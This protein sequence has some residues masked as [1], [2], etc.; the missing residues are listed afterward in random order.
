MGPAGLK[1]YVTKE[2]VFKYP[3]SLTQLPK[4]SKVWL[5][6]GKNAYQLLRG[7]RVVMTSYRLLPRVRR[8]LFVAVKERK[9]FDEVVW[10]LERPLKR[11]DILVLS[12]TNGRPAASSVVGKG[13]S[14]HGTDIFE[15]IDP[16][17]V[18]NAINAL[19]DQTI[20][21]TGRIGGDTL[22]YR[23]AIG[24]EREFDLVTLWQSGARSD[25]NLMLLNSPAP[26]QPGARNSL[27]QK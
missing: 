9:V 12:L 22:V 15:K 3:G 17:P 1:I 16:K 24:F 18:G 5:S 23:S 7:R 26:R 11:A 10:R 25:V 8:N 20:V 6:D 4:G 13:G 14:A 21:L 2:S 27:W 19:R